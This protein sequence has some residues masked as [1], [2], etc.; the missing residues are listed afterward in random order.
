MP[1][2]DASPVATD[3]VASASS[4]ERR[5]TAP[6]PCFACMPDSLQRLTGVMGSDHVAA[7]ITR[8]SY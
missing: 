5:E 1:E 7:L 4:G 8:V 3:F 6:S 2:C